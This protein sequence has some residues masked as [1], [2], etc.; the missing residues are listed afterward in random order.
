MPNLTITNVDVGSVI[1]RG[2]E[3]DDQTLT[4]AGGAYPRNI[5]EGTLLARDSVSGKMVV[6]AIGGTT[7]GNGVP[8]AILTYDVEVTVA[9]DVPIRNMLTGVVRGPRL[10]VDADGDASNITD[11]ILDV[12]RDYSINTL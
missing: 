1:L 7:N 11:I 3:F 6:Y 12:L 9:G 10:V 8:K 4:V 2:G 5:K